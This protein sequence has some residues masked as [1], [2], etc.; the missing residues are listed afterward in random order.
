MR[1][2]VVFFLKPLDLQAEEELELNAKAMGA[3][4]GKGGKGHRM[5]HGVIGMSLLFY[6]EKKDESLRGNIDVIKKTCEQNTI[7]MV[8]SNDMTDYPERRYA[9]RE[10]NR[11]LYVVMNMCQGCLHHIPSIRLGILLTA[12]PILFGAVTVYNCL[13]IGA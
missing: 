4:I 8:P 5:S 10:E 9:V 3:V 13:F 7:E 2:L 6:P 12:Q 11:L 1:I